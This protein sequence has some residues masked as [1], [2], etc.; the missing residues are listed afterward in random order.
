MAKDAKDE[1]ISKDKDTVVEAGELWSNPA[2]RSGTG[3]QTSGI[4]R[5][6]DGEDGLHMV[7]GSTA[8]GS[9]GSQSGRMMHGVAPD[10]LKGDGFGEEGEGEK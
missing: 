7:P 10:D 9:S 2:G 5:P 3:R 1:P 4:Q 6:R 8:T